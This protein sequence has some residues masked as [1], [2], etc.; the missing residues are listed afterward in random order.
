MMTIVSVLLLSLI[1]LAAIL[2]GVMFFRRQP[3]LAADAGRVATPSQHATVSGKVPPDLL[4][5]SGFVLASNAAEPCE[6][7]PAIT[8]YRVVA[9][10]TQQPATLKVITPSA[11]SQDDHSR[12]KLEQQLAIAQSLTHPNCAQ[13]LASNARAGT[14]YFVEEWLGEGSLQDYLRVGESL[15]EADITYLVGQLCDGLAYLHTRKLIHGFVTPGHIRFDSDGISHLIHCG[16]A[17]LVGDKASERGQAASA[18]DL[19]SL[20]VV[21]FQ[22]ATG[23]MPFEDSPA[24]AMPSLP[25]HDPRRFNSTLS[26]KLADAI[27]TALNPDRDQRFQNARDMARAFGYTRPFFG[28]QHATTVFIMPQV[29]H[30]ASTLQHKPSSLRRNASGLLNLFNESTGSLL[31]VQP[32][33]TII[34]R[35]MVNPNDSMISRYNGELVYEKDVWRLS[36]LADAISANGIFINEQ[37]V[38]TPRILCY[39]DVVRVGTTTLK[40]KD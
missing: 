33:R 23:H 35:D 16:F 8:I 12:R 28:M 5:A 10:D 26:A 25:K 32:P 34:T 30:T 14:P 11:L 18:S 3:S 37:R 6:V 19:Y 20:G 39:G 2:G 4:A 24:N 27:R 29:A 21:A 40:V 1:G 17:Q 13:I 7:S 38:T 36:E 22:M 31:A 9:T 15:A